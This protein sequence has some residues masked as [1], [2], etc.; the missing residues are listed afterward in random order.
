MLYFLYGTDT[1]KSRGK[2]H[3]LLTTLSKKRPESEVFK[4]TTEN[5]SEVQFEELLVSQGLF[6]QKYIVVLDNLFEKK[7]IK[8]FII[9][10][11]E[12]T[13]DD[14][15]V[16]LLLEGKVDA[17]TLKKIEKVAAKVQEFAKLETAQNNRGQLNI[18]SITDF[19]VRK[20]K[21]NLWVNYVDFLN[22]GAAAE[23]IHGVIFWQ[24]KNLLLVSKADSQKDTGL[25][26][27]VYK[28]ALSGA[29]NFTEGELE[30]MSSRLVNMTHRVR[31]GEGELEVMLEKWIL[32]V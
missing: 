31:I 10:R 20:D 19:L 6:D 16:F 7:D 28:S 12:Q 8:E 15:H 11:I 18:F 32:E 25:S 2:L 22:R 5:W 29:R 3:E 9:E 13:K 4:I 14:E 27:F 24:V 26:P 17:A 30:K 1:H 21:K 23:E